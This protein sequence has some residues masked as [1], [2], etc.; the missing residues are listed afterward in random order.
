MNENMQ[1]IVTS[2]NGNRAGV[3]IEDDFEIPVL[4]NEIVKINDIIGKPAADEEKPVTV[5]PNFVKVHSGFHIAFD[6]LDD[7]ML[8][9]KIHNSE[10]DLAMC[11]VYENNRLSQTLLLGLEQ[12][13][14][15]GKFDLREFARWPEFLFVISPL[16]NEYRSYPQTVKKIRLHA[17]EFHASF[18]QCYFLGRQAYVFRLDTDIRQP[19]LQKLKERD[20]SEPA[21]PGKPE[22]PGSSA[23]PGK[24]VDLHIGSL[25]EDPSA[26]TPQMM[27]DLQMKAVDDAVQAASV[28]KMKS[29]ILI[30]G[31]GN[32][33]LKNRIRNYLS[34][35][36]QLVE[37]YADA[38]ML[39]YGGGA[40]EVWLK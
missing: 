12:N 16:G 18:R 40:T 7:N 36:K 4:L 17:K 8:E 6:R 20:F 31:V 14:P 34:G 23:N 26:M 19:A 21:A 9:L 24:E 30:H 39:R 28:H 29:V 22:R 5:K 15:L 1:G 32:H 27:I 37:R 11:A 35:Q 2:I 10:S 3:T 13:K 33:F 38:D 25:V